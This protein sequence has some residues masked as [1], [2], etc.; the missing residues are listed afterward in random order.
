MHFKKLL[1]GVRSAGRRREHS[2]PGMNKIF[3][4]F[5]ILHIYINTRKR[6]ELLTNQILNNENFLLV[7]CRVI[8]LKAKNNAT[9]GIVSHV[10]GA[11]CESVIILYNNNS[12][13]KEKKKTVRGCD[14]N[15]A[16]FEI[17]YKYLKSEERRVASSRGWWRRAR[18]Q[19][20]VKCLVSHFACSGENRCDLIKF[21][22][23]RRYGNVLLSMSMFM[24]LLEIRT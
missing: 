14:A 17:N 15:M 24:K 3:L 6:G 7:Y 23:Q 11:G 21:S 10:A 9:L 2:S 4:F 20:R 1:T 5:Y 13:K 19:F 16:G 22:T 8:S 12:R 18:F